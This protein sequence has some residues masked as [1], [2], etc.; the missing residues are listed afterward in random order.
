[1][2]VFFWV[3]EAT[4]PPGQGCPTK[5][6]KVPKVGHI[7][8]RKCP[9]WDT[10]WGE[11]APGGAHF[12]DFAVK[13]P[14]VGQISWRKCPRV[15]QISRRNSPKTLMSYALFAPT[16][17]RPR[18]LKIPASAPGIECMIWSWCGFVFFIA[19]NDCPVRD[20]WENT[21]T[22]CRAG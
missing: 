4:L 5:S 9:R 21:Y 18:S 7:L 12:T 11:R 15:E 16:F 17:F 22:Y 20:S 3:A 8:R 19:S 14:G 13:V 1:M 10:V 6:R 2:C